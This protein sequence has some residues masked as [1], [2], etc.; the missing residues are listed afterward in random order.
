MQLLCL[1]EADVVLEPHGGEN[2][3]EWTLVQKNGKKAKLLWEIRSTPH[4]Y[5]VGVIF[6]VEKKKDMPVTRWIGR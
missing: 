2:K 6:V 5:L 3:D 4:L 1:V